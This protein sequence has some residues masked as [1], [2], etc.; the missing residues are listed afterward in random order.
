M[1]DTK[2]VCFFVRSFPVLSQT[3]VLNQ[4]KDLVAEGIDVHVLAVN[5]IKDSDGVVA[6]IFGAEASVKVSSILPNEH[7]TKSYL[8]MLLGFLFCLFSSQR[9]TLIKLFFHFLRKKNKFLAKDLMCIAWFLKSRDIE[10]KNCIAHF[11]NNGVIFDYLIKADLVKC[12][13]LFTIFHG[14]EIS[15]YEQLSIWEELYG[16][17]GGKLLPISNHWKKKLES[18]GVASSRIDVVHMGVDVNRFAYSEKPVSNPFAILSVARATEK[19]GLF[20]AIEAV[21]MCPLE[22]TYTI[23]G[24]GV[25]LPELQEL[26]NDHRNGHRVVFKGAQSSDFVAKSLK[27]TDLFLLPSIRDSSGDMEGIPVSLMEAM[28]SGV[29]VLSTV[30]SGIPELITDGESGFLVPEKNSAAISNKIVEIRENDNLDDIRKCARTKVDDD[31]NATKLQAQLLKI[32]KL[33]MV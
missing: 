7:N 23:I 9:F 30:H 28:A 31:F 18:L 8:F 6:D 4:V 27:T 19:K 11:G 24:D 1:S 14:Y 22:C 33:K 2:Q 10:I 26:V 25:L 3:F 17:M 16:K 5:P 15:R 12:D 13:N 21:L 32:L 29:V 20:Y